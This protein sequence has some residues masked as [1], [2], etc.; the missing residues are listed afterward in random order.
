MFDYI[1]SYDS[2]GNAIWRSDVCWWMDFEGWIDS[3]GVV[4]L[5][6]GEE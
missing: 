3:A 2:A 5:Y 6:G 4:H 1:M